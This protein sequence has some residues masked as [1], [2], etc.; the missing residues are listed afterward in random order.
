MNASF[1]LLLHWYCQWSPYKYSCICNCGRSFRGE[2]ILFQ[3]S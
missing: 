3:R 2:V 1:L